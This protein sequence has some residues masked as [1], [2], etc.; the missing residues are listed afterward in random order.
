FLLPGAD[1]RR[2]HFRLDEIWKG[3]EGAEIPDTPMFATDKMLKAPKLSADVAAAVRM[4][5]IGL[6]GA[7]AI[8]ARLRFLVGLGADPPLLFILLIMLVVISRILFRSD[9][10][11]LD[12]MQTIFQ[13]RQ[14]I[15]DDPLVREVQARQLQAVGLARRLQEQYDR[16]AGNERWGAMRD[17]L[18]NQKE[19][20]VNLAQIRQS[21][22][23][24]LEAEA[25]KNQLNEFLDQFEI[26]EAESKGVILPP[27]KKALLS[28]GVE[29]AAA[30]VEELKH[31]PS[32]GR[33]QAERLLRWR[34]D[35]E[36]RFV[37]DSAKSVP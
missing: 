37:F 32:V 11:S 20:Y 22:L 24:E 9:P 33:S 19:T 1:S 26:N 6:I 18:R 29:T 4:R 15:P 25:R 30:V 27:I 21:R 8:S 13:S 35:L 36:R 17:E 5:M 34:R 31:I 16:E 7:I 28:H 23:L 14:S 10:I 2:G 12:N 3:I